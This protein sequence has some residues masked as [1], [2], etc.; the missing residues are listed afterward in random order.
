MIEIRVFGPCPKCG[1]AATSPLLHF[2]SADKINIKVVQH[3]ERQLLC[4]DCFVFS[5]FGID[6]KTL[7]DTEGRTDGQDTEKA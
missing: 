7:L 4:N 5:K 2:D 6:T 1:N 3:E